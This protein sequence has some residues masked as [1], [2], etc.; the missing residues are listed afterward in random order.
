MFKGSKEN[1]KAADMFFSQQDKN[2][3]GH[4]DRVSFF[5][6]TYYR[7]YKNVMAYIKDITARRYEV[8]F[9]NYRIV[10]KITEDFPGIS[11]DVKMIH[12]QI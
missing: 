2:K 1:E 10:P 4:L 3:D 7:K 5:I 8:V 11:E 9:E 12:E 6:S